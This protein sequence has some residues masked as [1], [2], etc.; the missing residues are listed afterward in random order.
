M[1]RPDP[2]GAKQTPGRFSPGQSGNPSGRPK[3]SRNRVTVLVERMIE[4]EAEALTQTAIAMAKQ[5]DASLL[6]AMLDR[7]APAR[8][9]RTVTLDLPPIR[10]AADAPAVAARLVEA[11]A[12]GE[13][14][15]GEAQ[16]L[17][18]LLENYRRQAE[19]AEMEARLCALEASIS[20]HGR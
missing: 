6:R 20:A 2:A 19:L 11:A 17:G 7:L 12:A 18:A 3:G 5:G 16:S 14:T 4:G 9:E 10:N 1:P 15:P 13:I 8:K